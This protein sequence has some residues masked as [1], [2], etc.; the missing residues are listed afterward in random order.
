MTEAEWL[1][2]TGSDDWQLFTHDMQECLKGRGSYR[3]LTL[4]AFACCHRINPAFTDFRSVRALQVAERFLEGSASEE[5]WWA[6]YRESKV[7]GAEFQEILNRVGVLSPGEPS[8]A[9]NL[10]DTAVVLSHSDCDYVQVVCYIAKHAQGLADETQE[11]CWQAQILCDILGEQ[12][13][14]P[15]LKS[16]WYT[17][18]AVS[19]AREM[20]D[21]RDF[22]KMRYLGD[23]LEDAGCAN[24][25]VLNHCRSGG[26]HVRGCW[27]VDLLTGRS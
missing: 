9:A 26:A 17:D 19:L 5:E 24:E 15:E 13:P 2:C 3:K 21:S 8:G 6:A 7:V 12:E 1:A 16:S 11:R 27:I 4:F 23:A 20:Y 10:I 14:P 25:T 22:T 18:T